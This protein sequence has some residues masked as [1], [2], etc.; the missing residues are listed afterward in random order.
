MSTTIKPLT[1]KTIYIPSQD[2][3]TPIQELCKAG[4]L[5]GI[6]AQLLEDESILYCGTGNEKALIHLAVE[7]GHE[8]IVA[9]LVKRDPHCLAFCDDQGN[10]PLHTA[11]S[12]GNS[13]MQSLLISEMTK[14]NYS[15][16]MK[17]DFEQSPLLVAARINDIEAVERLL[18]AGAKA[19][20]SN[21]NNWTA[22]HS[23]TALDNH[24]MLS[25]LLQHYSKGANSKD[26]LG[27]TPLH[28]A[29][30]K[31]DL[32]AM[33]ILIDHGA[34]V[35]TRN[36]EKRTPMHEAARNNQVFAIRLL[37]ENGASLNRH[38]S[39]SGMVPLHVT[40]LHGNVEAAACLK[41]LGA[42]LTEVDRLGHTPAKWAEHANNVELAG[43]LNA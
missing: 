18:E 26:L 13:S 41:E 20:I 3:L 23:A 7:C 11:V 12:E 25:L 17:N 31:G 5:K 15:I 27:F 30:A 40:V 43:I 6:K 16:D 9:F 10:T 42:R 33:R 34:K 32:I 1:N 14:R 21:F 28:Y 39:D 2:G 36:N 29:A 22:F 19:N 24:D 35:N 38:E 8:H 4:D 37:Y